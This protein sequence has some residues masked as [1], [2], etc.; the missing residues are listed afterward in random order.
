MRNLLPTAGSPSILAFGMQTSKIISLTSSV[1]IMIFSLVTSL[2]T[3]S[4]SRIS[5]HNR[6]EIAF[7]AVRHKIRIND[8]ENIFPYDPS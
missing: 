8:T 4:I 6:V 5:P 3:R 2:I 7:Y 1:R